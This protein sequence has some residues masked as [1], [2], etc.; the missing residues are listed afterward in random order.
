MNIERPAS[1][2]AIDDLVADSVFS[3][4]SARG[5]HPLLEKDEEDEDGLDK[6]AALLDQKTT[7]V[8]A[9]PSRTFGG[10]LSGEGHC[11]VSPA[12]FTNFGTLGG[13]TRLV[14]WAHPKELARCRW[15]TDPTYYNQASIWE[16]C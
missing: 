7:T 6:G 4:T 9:F 2:L 5:L 8:D 14:R 1:S 10:P 3:Q 15:V 13:P 16:L 11:D 12:K